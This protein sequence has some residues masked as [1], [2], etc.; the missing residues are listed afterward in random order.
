[1]NYLDSY[2]SRVNHLG[3]TTAERIK[4]GGIRSFYKWMAE[5]PH[6]VKDLSVERNIHFSGIIL[7]NKDKE[8]QKIMFLNVGNDV[9]IR[10]GDILNWQLDDGQLE[11]WILFQEEKKVNGT[12]KTFYIVR[13]NYLVKWLDELGHLQSSWA[14]CVSSV[15]DKI[16]GNF[17]TWNSLITPQPNKYLEILMPRYEINRA[18][19]FIVEDESWSL[20]EYDYTSVPGIIYLSLTENKINLIYDDLDN[21]IA[22]LDKAAHYE[23]IT[24]ETT[25]T[26]KVGETI[27]P[28]FTL[29]KNGQICNYE[30]ILE[31]VNK[32][33]A[34]IVNGELIGVAE[35]NTDIIV[36]LKDFPAI[37]KTLH[38]IVSNNEPLEFDGYIEGP[39]KLKLDYGTNWENNIYTLKG[40]LP[41]EEQVYFSIEESNVATIKEF[42]ADYCKIQTNNKN[43]LGYFTLTASYQNKTYTKTV[44]VIPLW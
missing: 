4:N 42:S 12:Y 15:D 25:E 28:Q 23:I 7:T 37:T 21:D 8:Y 17:R 19:N 18:T 10:V 30:V 20:V 40:N 43:I 14:Y 41:I 34:R 13:C 29:M 22:D 27:N 11:K 24:A 33:V 3:T 35:G 16:K 9:P 39:D 2:F 5:S 38:I 36:K 44:Q 32:Q 31:P 6:T 1:M 26:F